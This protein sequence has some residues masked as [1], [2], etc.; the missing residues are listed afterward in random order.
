MAINTP[1]KKRDT[2]ADEELLFPD[3]GRVNSNNDWLNEQ[4]PE[5]QLAVDV[6]ETDNEIVLRSAIAGVTQD[7]LDVFLHN[8][9][10]TVRGVRH[11]EKEENARF[12]VKECHWG[13]FSRSI[14]LPT[15]V[16]P[17]GISAILKDGVLKIV[18]PKVER[19]RRIDISELQ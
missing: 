12:L 16:D 11:A 10:L 2:D 18:L 17:D 4:E 3:S 13:A 5:G 14:I 8:D 7:D 6:Y 15:D 19:S 1:L 9:L